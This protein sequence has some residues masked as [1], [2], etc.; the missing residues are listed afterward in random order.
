[1][2]K[3]NTIQLSLVLEAVRQLNCHA[4]AAQIYEVIVSGHPH[5]SRGTV[6]RNLN[7]LAATGE[8]R[9]IETPGGPERFECR[10]EEHYHARCIRCGQIFDVEM[11]YLIDL[12]TGIRDAHGFEISGHD[13]M[14]RGTCPLCLSLTAPNANARATPPRGQRQ[15]ANQ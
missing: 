2:I 15:K 8:I 12:E 7:R 3:R 1:M 9:K 5:I 11:D 6:Y 13:I 10:C 4:T 14:F